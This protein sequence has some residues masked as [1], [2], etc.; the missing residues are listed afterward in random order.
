[1]QQTRFVKD[2]TDQQKIEILNSYKQTWNMQTVSDELNI[3]VW[4]VNK[5]LKNNFKEIVA[6]SKFNQP[7]KYK[8]HRKYKFNEN[9]F[10]SIDTEEKAYF[11]GFLYA[12]GYVHK[13][14]Y[15][16]VFQLKE[17]DV[18]IINKFKDCLGVT[19]KL[20]LTRGQCRLSISSKKLI[21]D[22]EK[23][24]CGQAKSF[25]LKFPE[26][27]EN[28]Y[29]HFIRGY[30]DGD[31]CICLTSRYKGTSVSIVSSIDFINSLSIFL[32]SKGM[33]KLYV[34]EHNKCKHIRY[35]TISS[36]VEIKNFENYIYKD[37]TV[38]L[39]R[40]KDKFENV[41]RRTFIDKDKVWESYAKHKDLNKVCAEMGISN[42]SAYRIVKDID[43]TLMPCKDLPDELKNNVKKDITLGLKR[44]YIMSHYKISSSSYHRIKTSLKNDF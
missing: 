24:G 40:K 43:N 6:Q 30:F 27:N 11:L 4:T 23:Y 7:E 28:M 13:R 5:Y 26:L 36:K 31:G 12:D 20:Y 18:H 29:P 22:L 37:A 33:D 34:R 16:L 42:M 10:E 25:T 2:L 39:K 8:K 44:G 38:F 41:F 15:T 19:K 32:K 9:Y 1:M 14:S 17:N 3:S 21:T 35:L